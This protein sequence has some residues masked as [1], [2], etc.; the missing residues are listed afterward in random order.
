MTNNYHAQKTFY[1]PEEIQ[2]T[3]FISG[4]SDADNEKGD[5]GTDSEAKEA[6]GSIRSHQSTQ[7]IQVYPPASKR[8]HRAKD[9]IEEAAPVK[10]LDASV[11]NNGNKKKKNARDNHK[12]TIFPVNTAATATTNNYYTRY[13]QNCCATFLTNLMFFWQAAWICFIGLVIFL[14]GIGFAYDNRSDPI[15]CL[16]LLCFAAI[17][18][19]IFYY[20]IKSCKQI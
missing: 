20:G 19:V 17:G 4:G 2:P 14:L 9:I 6:K 11:T 18:C 5:N 8:V 13:K 3:N 1:Q 7:V 10:T 12:I 16:L 15:A